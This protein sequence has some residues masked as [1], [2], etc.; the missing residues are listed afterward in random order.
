MIPNLFWK[1]KIPKKLPEEMQAAADKL[2]RSKSKEDCLRKAYTLVTAR[3]KGRRWGPIKHPIDMLRTDLT[4]LWNHKTYM[5]CTHFNY[6]TRIL[7]VRSGFFKEDDIKPRFTIMAH[8]FL[9]QYLKVRTSKNRWVNVD[10]WSNACK[11]K[12]GEYAGIKFPYMRH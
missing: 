10:T 3:F 7:L 12:L 2:K 5:H 11:V 1:K 8:I 6:L 4:K 9:H